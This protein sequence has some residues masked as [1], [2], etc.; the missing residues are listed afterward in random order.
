MPENVILLRGNHEDFVEVDGRITSRVHPADSLFTLAAHAPPEALDGFRALFEAIPTS[1]I[2]DRTLFVHGGIPRDET[3]AAV[4]RDLSSLNDPRVRLEMMWSDP[5]AVDHV[6]QELQRQTAR[7]SFGR[8]QL[9]RFLD[10][11]GC[12]TLVRGHERFDNGFQVLVDGDGVRLVSLFSAGGATN[13]DL[14][15]DS[16]YRQ[17]VPMAAVVRHE[18]GRQSILPWAIAWELCN[19][20]HRNRLLWN[21]WELERRSG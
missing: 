13:A 7:F 5:S 6:P 10:R 14:P 21:P 15:E 4:W 11:V 9:R 12:H 17:T 16:S 1:F 19:A 2:F 18:H 3:T 20:P 8:Q